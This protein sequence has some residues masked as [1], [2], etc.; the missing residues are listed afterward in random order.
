VGA[1]LKFFVA[2]L[3]FSST[4]FAGQNSMTLS[5]QNATPMQ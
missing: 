3:V 1:V 4:M 2:A 5:A